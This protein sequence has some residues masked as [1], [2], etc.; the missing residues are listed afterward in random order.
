VG[1]RSVLTTEINFVK[2]SLRFL[3]RVYTT[4]NTPLRIYYVSSIETI[5]IVFTLA[6][7]GVVCRSV[8]TTEIN[9]VK[10]SLRFL[11]LCLHYNGVVC[12]SVLTT[13]HYVWHSGCK[14]LRYGK[15]AV[16]SRPDSTGAFSRRNAK[17]FAC[18]F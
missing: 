10:N 3:G 15:F 4:A 8:L 18:F 1:C 12:R 2:N 7:N 17:Y 9:L 11:A 13:D 16:A 6:Y 14:S 5:Y